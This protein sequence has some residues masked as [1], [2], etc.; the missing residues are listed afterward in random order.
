MNDAPQTPPI[1]S[2]GEAVPTGD[3]RTDYRD[4]LA[5]ALFE[6]AY[7]K[8]LIAWSDET[9]DFWLGRAD[10]TLSGDDASLRRIVE[11]AQQIIPAHQVNWHASAQDAL[12]PTPPAA[13]SGQDLREAQPVA[14][15]W[16]YVRERG[17]DGCWLHRGSPIAACEAHP[18]HAARE[19]QPLYTADALALLSAPAVQPGGD[20]VEAIAR[21]PAEAFWQVGHDG[22]G[23]D[24]GL[25]KARIYDPMTM[26]F[27][28]A[29][30]G[31]T[32][33]EAIKE[34]LA[35][36]PQPEAKEGASN[37]QG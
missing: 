5:R 6:A 8:T 35:A 27:P 26:G 3:D 11:R 34:A 36:T 9:R 13:S 37:G 18:G 33:A 25:F 2:S 24:P 14:W 31:E 12:S 19:V 28:L 23:A 20:L 4:R 10:A 30:W 17:P 21:I 15:R 16:R 7:S 22:E 1:A 32:P 29:G